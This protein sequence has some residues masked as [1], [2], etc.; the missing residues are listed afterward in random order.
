MIAAKPALPTD[1]MVGAIYVSLY[2]GVAPTP[3]MTPPS[4][5]LQ[6][7]AT[8]S[9]LP[10]VRIIPVATPPEVALFIPLDR[11]ELT[12]AE[13]ETTDP[14][15]ST[16]AP[17]A[18]ASPRALAA[19]E[20]CQLTQWIQAE[21]QA[22]PAV[23][24]ALA[25]IPRGA[26]SVANAIML[27]D[28]AWIETRSI[29]ATQIDPI[30]QAVVMGVRN[31]PRACVDEEMRGPLLMAVNDPHGATML[32]VGSGVWKWSQLLPPGPL[33]EQRN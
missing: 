13:E 29:T 8:I 11:P 20:S 17:A 32:A 30:R 2:D 33:A 25:S 28:G 1:A 3:S 5:E 10:E 16:T 6:A 7:V 23:T 9:P 22:D 24:T 12:L 4:P 31:A 15:D 19:G 14:R 18:A 26:R 21:L 27:W